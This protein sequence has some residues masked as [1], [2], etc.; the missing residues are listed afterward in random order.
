MTMQQTNNPA[1]GFTQ[2]SN[3]KIELVPKQS[4]TIDLGN[5]CIARSTAAISL[6]EAS[7]PPVLYIP[8]SDVLAKI[9]KSEKTSYCPFKGTASY[10]NIEIGGEVIL[11]AAWSY[12]IPYDEM[13]D[14]KGHLAFYPNK[15][16]ISQI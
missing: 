5:E 13:R 10:W 8:R 1:P 7:Y 2:H 4:V 9:S 3:H 11:D 16:S 6:L 14:I 15:V 12:D